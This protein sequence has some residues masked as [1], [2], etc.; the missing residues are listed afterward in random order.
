MACDYCMKVIKVFFKKTAK[1]K[2]LAIKK[3]SL[4]ITTIKYIQ[5]KKKYIDLTSKN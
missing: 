3:F 4:S 2:F 5:N 1:E